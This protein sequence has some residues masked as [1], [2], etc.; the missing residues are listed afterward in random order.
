M[1][2]ASA[3]GSVRNGL[4][5]LELSFELERRRI[6][7]AECGYTGGYLPFSHCVM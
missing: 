6:S 3:Y 7:D 1:P 4:D 5:P 2:E